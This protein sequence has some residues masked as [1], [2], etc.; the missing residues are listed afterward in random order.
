MKRVLAILAAL[1]LLLAPLTAFSVDTPN[2]LNGVTTATGDTG[3]L[4]PFSCPNGM[5]VRLWQTGT[6]NGDTGKIYQYA[7]NVTS[8]PSASTV[9]FASAFDGS[10]Y[11]SLKPTRYI[12]ITWA[13]RSAGAIY[14]HMECR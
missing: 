8:E 11:W 5:L 7:T 4:G 1:A 10:E 3:R 2:L 6:W 12:R 14:G 13:N 9:T